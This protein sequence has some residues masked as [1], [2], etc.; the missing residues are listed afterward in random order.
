MLDIDYFKKYNDTFGHLIGDEILV[1]LCDIIRTHIT[2]KA[3]VGRWGGEEFTIA[4]PNSNLAQAIQVAERIRASMALLKVRND[5]QIA[6]S[7]PTM[8][9]GI[10]VYPEDADQVMKLIDLADKRLYV[11]KERGRD[12]IESAL[13]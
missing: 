3:A 1:S 10:A 6:I 7:V 11:A 2:Q 4:L 13:Q 5:S 9:M 8:S 12:Q